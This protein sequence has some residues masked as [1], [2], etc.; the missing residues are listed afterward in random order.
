[1]TVSVC[2]ALSAALVGRVSV[3]VVA[4]PVVGFG[5]KETPSPV[6][7]GTLPLR[8]TEPV[9]PLSRWIPILYCLDAPGK[10]MP[11]RSS[12]TSW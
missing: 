4:L 7:P 6:T 3:A 8:V 1:M 2:L 12:V 10:T 9:N 11:P 5:L